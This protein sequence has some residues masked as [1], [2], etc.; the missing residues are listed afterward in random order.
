MSVKLL[1]KNLKGEKKSQFLY[2]SPQIH[3][4]ETKLNYSVNALLLNCIN[5]YSNDPEY[6]KS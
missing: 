2:N 5:F 6:L 3:D 1:P 4:D